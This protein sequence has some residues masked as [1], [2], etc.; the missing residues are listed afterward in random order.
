MT[1]K[2][3][4]YQEKGIDGEKIPMFRV[5]QYDS[6]KSNIRYDHA[7]TEI[8]RKALFNDYKI[9]EFIEPVADD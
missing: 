1:W 5:V 6:K 4:I 3:I 2:I 9:S 8:E 7:I